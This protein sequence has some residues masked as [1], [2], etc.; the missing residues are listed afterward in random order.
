MIIPNPISSHCV[1]G[2]VLVLICITSFNL[3]Q[4]PL[5]E[6]TISS[7]I[8]YRGTESGGC[9]ENKGEGDSTESGVENGVQFQL[10][11]ILAMI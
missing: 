11:L 7:S 9:T 6:Q 4:Q 1:P 2:T 8:S 10:Q 5:E 3:H